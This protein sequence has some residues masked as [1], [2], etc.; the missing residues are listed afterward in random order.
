[1]ARSK[2]IFLTSMLFSAISLSGASLVVRWVKDSPDSLSVHQGGHVGRNRAR[3]PLQ[4]IAALKQGDDAPVGAH[5]GNVHQLL[6]D[7]RVVSLDEIEIGE[8]VT[9]VRVESGRDDQNVRL[10]FTQT[11]E[12]DRLERFLE[13]GTTVAG[14]Q[15]RVD[16]GVEFA[17]LADRAGARAKRQLVG[18]AVTYARIGPE[19][20]LRAI[21]MVDIEINNCRPLDA[22]H[23]LRVTRGNG[24]VVEETEA[25]RPCRL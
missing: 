14:R 6:G 22:M 2:G 3:K 16:N 20:V 21:A 5:I 10:E 23:F 19:D 12:N 4:I 8:R 24:R 15:W 17:S 18:G 13:S 11:W 1:M 9:R 25:H 7:P